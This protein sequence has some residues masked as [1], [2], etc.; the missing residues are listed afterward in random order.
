[1]IAVFDTCLDTIRT[2]PVMQ[3]D[4]LDPEDLDTESEDHIADEI[5]YACMSRPWTPPSA[6]ERKPPA[7][8]SGYRSAE[9]TSDNWKAA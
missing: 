3:H 2:L 7:K 8:R 4:E 1:M 5:R 6:A 9:R